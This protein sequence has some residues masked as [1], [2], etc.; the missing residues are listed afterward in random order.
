MKRKFY[1]IFLIFLPALLLLN[2]CGAGKTTGSS[3]NEDEVKELL[4][5]R[6][7]KFIATRAFPTDQ[8][9]TDIMQHMGSGSGYRILDL[10]SGNELT[11]KDRELKGSLPFFGRLYRSNYGSQDQSFSFDFKDI[12][13]E[14][15]DKDKKT[16]LTIYPGE[17][18]QSNVDKLY[19][20]IFKNGKASLSVSANDRQ[21]ISYNGYITSLKENN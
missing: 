3:L 8:A 15:T 10:N 14:Q 4:D 21:T 6:Q 12:Q 11:L 18:G 5:A 19:F 9:V 1:S 17:K 16:S 7:F 2:S 13:I 20:E